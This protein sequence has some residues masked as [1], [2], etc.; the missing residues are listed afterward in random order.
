MS[1]SV[2]KNKAK[3]CEIKLLSSA[4]RVEAARCMSKLINGVS[5]RVSDVVL[6]L[7][8]PTWPGGR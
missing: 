7:R 8:F 6:Q 3:V 4:D 2:T 5:E 1:E